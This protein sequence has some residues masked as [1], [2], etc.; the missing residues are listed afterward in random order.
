MM[1]GD[2][3]PRSKPWHYDWL[4]DTLY[5]SPWPL[6]GAGVALGFGLGLLA[7]V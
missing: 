1:A 5:L 2:F 6:F 3:K 4:T 7:A